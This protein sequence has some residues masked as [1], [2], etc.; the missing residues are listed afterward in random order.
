M[1]SS[2]ENK[3]VPLMSVVKAAMVDTYSDVGSSQELFMHF[4][5]RELDQLQTQILKR[6]KRSVLLQVNKNTNTATLPIDFDSELFV[7]VINSRHYKIPLR[8]NNRITDTI[9]I[10]TIDYS[11]KCEKCNQDKAICEDLQITEEVV[12]K[13]INGTQYEQ[14]IIKK[15]YPNGDYY[16]ETTTPLWD[17]ELETVNYVTDK[18]FISHFDLKPCGCLETTTDNLCT[19]E[20]CCPD[21]YCQYYAPCDYSCDSD[22][23]GYKVFEETGLIQFDFSFKYD[24]VYL[25][26]LGFIPKRNGQ[27]YVPKV[28]FETL[29]EGVK[30]RSVEARKNVPNVEKI[31]RLQRY[32]AAKSGL[33]K[34]LGR[35]SLASIVQAAHSIP[36]FNTYTESWYSCFSSCSQTSTSTSTECDVPA[37]TASASTVISIGGGNGLGKT[38]EIDGSSFNENYEYTNSSL[39]NMDL[40]VFANYIPRYL[41][42]GTEFELIPY[43]IRLLNMEGVTLTADDK[44][45]II[46]NGVL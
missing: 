12:F 44:L 2:Y 28:A 19:L 35:V 15:L 14:R 9:H 18:K 32:V 41:N 45:K 7:G 31:F 38:L 27:F 10:D 1:P 29:V 11:E 43:G 46:P 24:Y 17:T 42:K 39:F 36:K 6:G 21:V 20:T 4:A 33:Q 37:T 8:L 3:L 22:L 16:L 40:L 30:F 34:V 23:G 13:T 5:S 25:E 26:Y